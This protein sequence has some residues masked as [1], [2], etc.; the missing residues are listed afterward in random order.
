M[1][2]VGHRGVGGLLGALAARAGHRVICLSDP[3]SVADLR[4]NGLTVRSARHGSFTVAVESQTRLREPVDVLVVAVKATMLKTALDRVAP[5]ALGAGTV[6][7]LLNGVEHMAPLRA[8]YP[9]SQVVAGAIWPD[10]V[11]A[12]SSGV[13]YIIATAG[14]ELA[15]DTAPRGRIDGLADLLRP[16]GIDV[17]VCQDEAAMLLAKL[18]FVGPLALLCTYWEQAPDGLRRDWRPEMLAAI[19]EAVAVARAAGASIDTTAVVALFDEL[20]PGMKSSMHR[21]FEAGRPTELDALGGALL[22]EA[23]RRGI[24]VPG[25]DRL[26]TVLRA[27]EPRA[28]VDA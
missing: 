22:R 13:D 8:R 5:E 16:L 15:S 1:V 9:A 18:A 24:E 11:D 2:I 3:D 19:E 25:T 12:G 7:A 20:P 28:S 10:L 26:V 23:A 6:L 4:V 14:I 17:T 27:R 21:D